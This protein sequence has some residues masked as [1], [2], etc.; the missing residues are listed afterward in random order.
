MRS[1]GVLSINLFLYS[2]VTHA[3][4]LDTGVVIIS[5]ND[6]DP[7]NPNRAGALLLRTPLAC[8]EAVS[9]CTQ[10]QETLLPPPTNTGFTSENLTSVLVSDR[11]G[12][13]LA[14]GSSVWIAGNCKFPFTPLHPSSS[15]PQLAVRHS[16]WAV[17]PHMT[18][19]PTFPP[20]CPLSVPTLP[21]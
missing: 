11:H 17:R 20:A 14:P 9:T 6:L 15:S 2:R 1:L 18:T 19:H 5:N 10:L 3:L 21:R 13:A 4:L 16:L 12:A 7:S 8:S